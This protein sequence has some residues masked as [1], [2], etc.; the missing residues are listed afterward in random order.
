MDKPVRKHM[1]IAPPRSMRPGKRGR[2]FTR[3][4]LISGCVI[5]L[6]V[7]ALILGGYWYMHRNDQRIERNQ[8]QAV[9]LNDGKVFFGKLQN[10][11]GQYITVTDAYYTQEQGASGGDGAA[12]SSPSVKLI[13]VGDETYGPEGSMSI[14]SSNVLFWQNLRADSKVAKAIESNK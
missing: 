11:N 13:K 1:D 6:A 4:Q 7:V 14:E 9:F 5:A 8:Y 12:A 3:K 2:R 10:I